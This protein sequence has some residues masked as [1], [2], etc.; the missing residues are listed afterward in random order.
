MG[1]KYRVG[2]DV[3]YSPPVRHSA[4]PGPYKIVSTLPVESEGRHTYR[5]RS[6]IETFERTAEESELTLAQSIR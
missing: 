3:Y 6:V 5:I 1:H 2:Q 4:A